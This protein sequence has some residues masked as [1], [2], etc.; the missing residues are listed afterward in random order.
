ME[1]ASWCEKCSAPW[2]DR[3]VSRYGRAVVSVYGLPV[4]GVGSGRGYAAAV[5]ETSR[6]RVA[7]VASMASEMRAGV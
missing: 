6:Y 2:R 3:T 1:G 7:R 5:Q 4:H